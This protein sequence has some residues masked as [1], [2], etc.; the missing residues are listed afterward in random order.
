M[1]TDLITSSLAELLGGLAGILL[2][3]VAGRARLR[4]RAARRVAPAEIRDVRQARTYTLP[5]TL[6]PD[7]CPV[8][9]I[10][11]RPAGTILYHSGPVGREKF[12]L[13]DFVLSDGTYAA[14]PLSRYQ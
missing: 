3:A 14:E 10:S 12:E 11:T 2:L 13:T 5:G 7:G 1:L 4:R 6:A 8:K 9:V